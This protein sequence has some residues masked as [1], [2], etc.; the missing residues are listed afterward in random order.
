VNLLVN[1]MTLEG[2]FPNTLLIPN[3]SMTLIS[4][5]SL[6]GNHHHVIFDDDWAEVKTKPTGKLIIKAVIGHGGVYIIQSH[7]PH[8]H[9]TY[10]MKSKSMNINK[11]HC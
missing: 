9:S 6:T 5:R 10:L 8:K 1:G 2:L 7:N 11:I 4:I 3:L